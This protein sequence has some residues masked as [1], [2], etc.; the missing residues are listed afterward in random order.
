MNRSLGKSGGIKIV[1]LW[2]A[3]V[4]GA[5]ACGVTESVEEPTGDDNVDNAV[6]EP[7]RLGVAI[8]QT[9]RL[10]DSAKSMVDSYRL[11][12]TTINDAGGLD[13]RP[14]E[15]VI[16]DDESS[17]DTARVLAERLVSRDEVLLMLG[18]YGSG[19]AAAM[20][21]VAERERVPLL[22]TIASN[23][24]IWT[25]QAWNW[26]VQA[27]PGAASDHTGFLEVAAANGE[28]RVALVVET[29]AFVTEG[30][31]FAIDVTAPALGLTLD[32]FSWSQ[33]DLDFS[34]SLERVA[35]GGYTAVSVMG[36]LPGVIS[37]GEAM[38]ERGL[39][40]DG[41]M[42]GTPDESVENA[43][44]ANVAQAFARTPWHATLATNGNAE[45]VSLYEA[46]YGRSPDY[47][48]AT[49]W[50]SGQLVQQAIE[51]VG[52]DR[53]AIMRFM[54]DT[55]VETVFGTYEVDARGVQVGYKNVTG[56]W[57][58]PGEFVIVRGEGAT[59][60]AVWPKASWR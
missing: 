39:Q 26:F 15:L 49:G 52:T 14:V 57:R 28:E 8:A 10:A 54:Y 45:F 22:G 27:Y 5:A 38:I 58:G 40:V 16:Y 25:D 51:S 23:T 32:V 47:Q 21:I 1:T 36:Y 33:E 12:E 3:L 56:Q 43:L 13:G 20:G 7:I 6:K 4:L 50:A 34:S 17:A 11:W 30:V 37:F 59:D 48:A 18:P 44:G 55:K 2:L 19:S 41:I 46:T 42:L 31:N 60:A 29:T 24:A 9:G 53:Q 35:S